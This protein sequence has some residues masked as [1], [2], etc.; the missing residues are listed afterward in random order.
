[1]PINLFGLRKPAGRISKLSFAIRHFVTIVTNSRQ[2][3]SLKHARDTHRQVFT[4]RHRI[5]AHRVN[6]S[7][8]A[9][10]EA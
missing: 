2:H 5:V 6:S 7:E 9:E 1:M 4:P 3:T 10:E 8:F